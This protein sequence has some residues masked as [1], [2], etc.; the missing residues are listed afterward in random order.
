MHPARQHIWSVEWKELEEES[1]I[2]H[3]G[4]V[5]ATDTRWS[6][7][8][9][10]CRLDIKVLTFETRKPK[11]FE[12]NMLKTFHG[13]LRRSDISGPRVR[14]AL[15]DLIVFFFFTFK[16]DVDTDQSSLIFLFTVKQTVGD[17]FF[18]RR[19]YRVWLFFISLAFWRCIFLVNIFFVC[20]VLLE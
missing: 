15:N 5:I 20:I 14:Q 19:C 1:V 8:H 3:L 6:I 9:I 12:G 11:W 4:S 10:L 17:A 13:R 16:L 2:Q 7:R 18:S